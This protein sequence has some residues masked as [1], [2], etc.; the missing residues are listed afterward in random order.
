MSI[1]KNLE[2]QKRAAVGGMIS[3]ALIMTMPT[4]LMPTEILR[5]VIK[6]IKVSI[7]FLGMPIALA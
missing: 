6:L 3:R 5:M 1:G 4:A 7:R 2:V